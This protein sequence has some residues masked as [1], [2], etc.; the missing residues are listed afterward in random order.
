M[1]TTPDQRDLISA[2]T[3]IAQAFGVGGSSWTYYAPASA[4]NI[5]TLATLPSGVSRTLYVQRERVVQTG[6]AAPL[7]PVGVDR[8]RLIALLAADIAS[9]G[10]IVSVADTSLAFT[11]GPLTS[12]QGYWSAILEPTTNP[13]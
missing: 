5:I 8:W 6:I 11:I 13:A 4:D 9:G 1:S 2:I 12:D 3:E 7:Q 10:I